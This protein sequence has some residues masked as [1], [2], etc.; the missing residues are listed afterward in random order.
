MSVAVEPASPLGLTRK[1]WLILL[2][3]ATV[4]LNVALAVID[5]RLEATGGP[6][7]LGLE[8]AGSAERV[9]EIEAEWGA[10]GGDLARL[11]LWLDF[12]FMLSYGA[13]FALAGVA[14]RD[15]ASAHG[16]R[17][18]GACG[19]VAP[20]LAI[21]AAG[22]DAAENVSWLLLLG[23]HGASWLAPFATACAVVKFVAIVLVIGYVVWGLVSRLRL[24]RRSRG[25]PE[26]D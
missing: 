17:A 11:S 4:A 13:F 1:R 10:H 25:Q 5:K 15:F 22:F 20:F 8:F 9:A 19:M 16:L 23:G 12:P 24:R 26:A 3:L 21:V 6:S 2:G 14:T 7:I 18:L